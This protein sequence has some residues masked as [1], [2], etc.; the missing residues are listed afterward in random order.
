MINLDLFIFP[1]GHLKCREDKF[2]T[3]INSRLKE[4][5]HII[6]HGSSSGYK[7]GFVG[8]KLHIKVLCSSDGRESVARLC[9]RLALKSDVQKISIDM[10]NDGL[11]EE[12]EFPDPDL[13]IVCGKYFRLYGYPPWQVRLTEFLEVRTVHLM[14]VLDFISLLERFSR[15]QQRFG[16]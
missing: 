13:G 14:S 7:N 2:K 9:R 1:T 11:R 10:V 5:E 3:A 16:K 12:F 6:W 8:R 4:D 15:C